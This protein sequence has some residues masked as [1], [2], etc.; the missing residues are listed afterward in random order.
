MA[1]YEEFERQP[2]RLIDAQS[3]YLQEAAY[4]PVGW[5]EFGP[6]AFAEA[7][8][9]DKPVF[10]DIGAA[11]CHWCHVMDRESYEDQEIATYLNELYIPIK[12]DRDERP[13]LDAR[14][15]A[16]MQLLINQGGWPLTVFLTQD[17]DPFYGGTYFPPEDRYGRMGLKTV[18]PRLADYYKNRR[19]EM[20]QAAR[21]LTERTAHA[22]VNMVSAKPVTEEASTQILDGIRSRFDEEYGGF[23]RGAPK[24]PHAGAIELALLHCYHH[25]EEAW[26]S[27]VEQTLTAMALG[28]IY[29]QLGGGFHRY[30]TDASWIVPHFEKMGYDNAQLLSN[31]VHAYRAFGKNLYR[32]TAEG[33][34]EYIMHSLAD[35]KRGGFFSTQDA[36]VGWNDDGSYWTWTFA[37]FTEA[38]TPD[39]AQVLLR[40]YDVTRDGDMGKTGRNVLHVAVMP[41]E[42]ARDMHLPVEEIRQRIA[43]GKA[44]LQAV[45]QRRKTPRID[46]HKYA[47][48]NALLISA[49][50][51]AGALLDREDAT[52]FA[53]RSARVLIDD[54]YEDD[55]GIYHEFHTTVGAR[56]PGLFEDQVYTAVA[57]LDA[58]AASGERD[59]LLTARHLLDLCILQYW[60]EENG[61]FLDIA[62]ARGGIAE[63]ALLRGSRKVIEDMPTPASNAIAALALDRLWLLTDDDQYH[64]YARRTLETFATHAP[65]YG[66]FTATFGLA[67]Y[68]H[69]HPPA[70]ATIV[71]TPG[72]EDTERL[73]RAALATY[74]PGRMVAVY[75]PDTPGVTYSAG[76]ENSARGYVCAGQVCEKPVSDAD[77]LRETLQT[78][79][80]TR[81]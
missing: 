46:T 33:T 9:Q 41:E 10:L 23:E 65:D 68:F 61:G 31:Y 58:F 51:E 44:K 6:E 63:T 43:R 81:G 11:W 70:L 4:Q 17:G 67:V 76:P 7:K 36:D 50:L 14:F 21:V 47:N 30:S 45:R 57:L 5:Y 72:A 38:L 48:W 34:L 29:D 27:M 66:P 78:I 53:L 13:D 3:A 59:Y 62:R 79:G 25:R 1:L 22:G 73:W 64:D 49:C 12:V 69:L 2:N 24:F 37:E 20:V 56:L 77:A 39:E 80:I 8:R 35:T 74:R 19:L 18:L 40:Y 60:D 54:A 16:A 28:G 55:H 26:R 71:G 42:I 15:Q 52:A 32:E 75:P